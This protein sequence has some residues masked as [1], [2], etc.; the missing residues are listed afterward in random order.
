MKRRTVFFLS[1][2]TGITA[3]TL[4]LSLISQFADIDFAQVTLPFVDSIEKA[5]GATNRIN[6]AFTDDG[7]KPIV[8]ATIVNKDIRAI[9]QISQ[10]YYVDYFDTFI[11][12]LET[13]LQTPSSHAMGL[14][15]SVSNAQVY[16]TRIEAVNFS[17]NYDDGA[18]TTGYDSADVILIG[19]SRC[20][21]TPTSLYLAMQFG[22]RAANYPLTEEDLNSRFPQLPAILKP[23]RDKL[24][25]L[26][27]DPKRLHAIRLGR[28]PNSRYATTEQ[29]EHEVRAVEALF[30]QENI[31][32]LSS[33]NLS[34]EELATKLMVISGIERRLR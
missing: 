21:K 30:H 4:G 24:F 7:Q 9:L 17:L 11:P 13:E 29:C 3:E 5:M 14:I 28:S 8:F 20:G 32:Y 2:R 18:R 33:T 27:I 16:N 6:Q 22:I 25:G 12:G 26:T 1:D 23:H 10:A 15:H 19:V 34:I 31:P